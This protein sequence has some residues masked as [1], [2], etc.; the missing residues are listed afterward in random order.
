MHDYYFNKI[1]TQLQSALPNQ[2]KY[3]DAPPNT[4]CLGVL[5]KEPGV[6]SEWR[7][8]NPRLSKCP[9]SF[10]TFSWHSQN[11]E[12][13]S[14]PDWHSHVLVRFLKPRVICLHI[15]GNQYC[16]YILSSVLSAPRC[17]ISVW[18]WLISVQVRDLG[19]TGNQELVLLRSIFL[20]SM[21]FCTS[22][23]CAIASGNSLFLCLLIR[24]QISLSRFCST[25]SQPWCNSIKWTFL[26]LFVATVNS[27]PWEL[28]VGSK[29]GF[30]DR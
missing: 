4:S 7:N 10:L 13:P 20:Y 19:T 14:R 21:P 23:V 12:A 24:S 16:S 1:P 18:T 30:L 15:C 22:Y 2:S 29:T 17:I 8:V 26:F 6:A 11:V 3:N 25:A 9:L 5:Q 28:G 27:S